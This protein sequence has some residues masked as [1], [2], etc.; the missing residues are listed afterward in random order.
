MPVP[1]KITDPTHPRFNSENFLFTDY[2][3]STDLGAAVR[4]MFPVGTDKSVIDAAMKRAG[5]RID[6]YTPGR[7]EIGDKNL[8]YYRQRN[9]RSVVLEFLTMTPVNE[10]SWNVG[11]YYDDRDRVTKIVGI[12]P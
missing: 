9:W 7:T 8:Y 3:N 2:N 6:K 5:V 12:A 10:F 4:A 1:W 11:I